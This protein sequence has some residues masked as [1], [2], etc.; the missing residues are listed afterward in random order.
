VEPNKNGA[1]I[2]GKVWERGKAEPKQWTIEF[3]DP[4]PITEGAPGLYCWATG[5]IQGQTGAEGFFDNVK[6]T[7]KK[8]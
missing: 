4:F 1:K 5:I 2:L 7:P 8:K 3:D 6:V